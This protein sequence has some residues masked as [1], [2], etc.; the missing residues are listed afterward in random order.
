MTKE[1]I[2]MLRGLIQAEI[3]YAT[4]DWGNDMDRIFY[5]HTTEKWEQFAETFNSTPTEPLEIDV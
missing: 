4:G 3:E 2:E 1:Q 5:S